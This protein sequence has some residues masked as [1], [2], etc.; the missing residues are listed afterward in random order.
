MRR[1]GESNLGYVVSELKQHLADLIQIYKERSQKVHK[2]KSLV[3]GEGM[4]YLPF[5]LH[6]LLS[7]EVLCTRKHRDRLACEYSR[8]VLMNCSPIAFLNRIAPRIYSLGFYIEHEQLEALT[9]PDLL[10][11]D[12]SNVN[13]RGKGFVNA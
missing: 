3:L 5:Y 4:R 12:Y 6:C 11:P 8:R 1:F 9:V 10:S 7:A 2:L 13:N